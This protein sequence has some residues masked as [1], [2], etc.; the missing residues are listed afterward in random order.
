M[1][2]SSEK[3][4]EVQEKTKNNKIG[5]GKT[6][7]NRKGQGCGVAQLVVRRLAVRQARVQF[8]AR[9]PT[10]VFTTE[11]TSDEE[12]ERNFGECRRMNILCECD[13]MN[14]VWTINYRNKQKEL[15]YATLPKI[16]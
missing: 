3:G 7:N 11:L 9:H 10:E 8:S 12:I 5:K 2:E 15:H 13:G 1:R 16:K 6:G 14:V 4:R